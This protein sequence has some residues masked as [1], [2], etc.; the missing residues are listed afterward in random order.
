MGYRGN[1]RIRQRLRADSSFCSYIG[2]DAQRDVRMTFA[3]P[4]LPEF[5]MGDA[6]PSILHQ[7]F[8]EGEEAIPQEIREIQQRLRDAN[9]GWT[10]SFW[11]S[12]RAEAFIRATYGDSILSRYLSI[13][14]E[15]YAARSDLL[16]YLALYAQGGVYLDMKS[17]C[18][19]PLDLALR[20]D[21]KFLLISSGG[22]RRD[23][24]DI[25]HIPDG[26]YHQWVIATVAGHPF[27]RATIER[28][29]ENIDR[30]RSWRDGV[31]AA[32][33]LRVTGP[34][35]YTLAINSILSQHP[36][37]DVGRPENRSFKYSALKDDRAHKSAFGKS[38]HYSSL[39]GPLMRVSAVDTF[40]RRLLVGA[41]AV[42][43]FALLSRSQRYLQ[44]RIQN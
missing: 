39:Q 37:T 28:V 44:R 20:R 7:H 18:A 40:I 21:E 29:I 33:T 1:R 38:K 17:F 3:R 26:E 13:E 9:P 23:L 4:E 12:R 43:G 32:G 14:P 22:P 8:L 19:V 10:Y 24:P 30:Y 16:R 27:L 42:P 36:F 15:Y 5:A 6:I 34:I 11:D 25:S 41:E 35:P 31:G 2:F